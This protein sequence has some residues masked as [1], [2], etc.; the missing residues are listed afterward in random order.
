MIKNIIFDMGNV[1]IEFKPE[2][3]L[4]RMGIVDENERNII[5][6]NSVETQYWTDYDLGKTTIKKLTDK[7]LKKIPDHLKSD[8]RELIRNWHAYAKPVEGMPELVLSLK[9]K[10]YKLYV[11]SN[12]GYNQPSYLKNFPYYSFDGKVVSAFY[13]S[14][15]PNK[16]IYEILLKKYNLNKAECLF[17]D[18]I[19]ENVNG[20]NKAGIKAILFKDT[21]TL[22][23]QL[24]ELL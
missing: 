14:S 13:R 16:K 18:D 2:L 24:E 4:K 12:A 22:K 11:L 5:I 9:R 10:E 21:E 1:L 17:I 8:A 3:F 23:K 7:C 6:N 19:Q 15:K 20:A